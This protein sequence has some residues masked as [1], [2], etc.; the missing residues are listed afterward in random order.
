MTVLRSIVLLS[1]GCF[2]GE[3]LSLATRRR[4]DTTR[5]REGLVHGTRTTW[6]AGGHGLLL[7]QNVGA[8]R[9]GARRR[10]VVN[11]RIYYLS[12]ESLVMTCHLSVVS[13]SAILCVD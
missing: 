10:R 7:L 12:A 6:S 2:V 13:G 9:P 11:G 3:R 5:G 8:R 1:S 4:V